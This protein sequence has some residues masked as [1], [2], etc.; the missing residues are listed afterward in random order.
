MLKDW[1]FCVRE[2]GRALS[3]YDG[4]STYAKLESILSV[5]TSALFDDNPSC[6]AAELISEVEMQG[7][8]RRAAFEHLRHG[9]SLGFLERIIS[10]GGMSKPESGTLGRIEETARI[11]LSPLGR[12]IRAADRLRLRKF[13]DFV[14]TT[15]LLDRDFDMYGLLLRVAGD[16]HE[17]ALSLTE[18]SRH[19]RILLQQR[20][21][22]LDRH[23]L[24]RPVKEQVSRYLA[25]NPLIGDTSI[26]D[27]SIKHHFN[28]RRQ[29]ARDLSHIEQTGKMTNTLTDAGK[30][31][32]CQIAT[33]ASKNSMSWLAPTPACG[34]KL[35]IV[36]MPT[37]TVFSAWDLFRPDSLEVEPG[38]EMIHEVVEFMKDSFEIIRL[39]AFAQAPI[40]AIIPYVHFQE[41]CRNERVDVR[42]TLHA[43]IKNYRDI[44]YCMLTAVPEDCHYQ[45]RTRHFQT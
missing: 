18:F 42:K 35:G 19:F 32:A 17:S 24:T 15:A 13:R 10:S 22:W 31:L 6:Y 30:Q 21:E 20:K 8:S 34:T 12:T 11:T 7:V 44:V 25:W 26:N 2:F 41:V 29:W 39:Q 40:A 33:V 36:S 43:V 28:M 4:H 23:V 3:R 37:E 16:N 9:I 38:P 27:T 14:I 1:Q 45:L 5:P